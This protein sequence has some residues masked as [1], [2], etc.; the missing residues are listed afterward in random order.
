VEFAYNALGERTAMRTVPVR[1]FYRQQPWP[2]MDSG[3]DL[4]HRK[5]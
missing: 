1:G 2:L 5:P 3:L 4:K